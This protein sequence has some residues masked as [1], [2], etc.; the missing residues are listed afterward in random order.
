M[1]HNH[2]TKVLAPAEA[3]AAAPPAGAGS[4]RD[5][6]SS[7][8]DR[9]IT[10]AA[11]TT[12]PAQPKTPPAEPPPPAPPAEPPA[13]PP[14]AAP[15]TPPKP[16]TPPTPAARDFDKQPPRSAKEWAEA[17]AG[18]KAEYEPKLAEYDGRVKTLE[19][20]LAEARKAA[21]TAAEGTSKAE[22]AALEAANQEIEQLTETIRRLNVA[23]HP[24]FKAYFDNKVNAQVTLA[25]NIV[26]ADKAEQAAKVLAL[27]D[28]PY[29]SQQIEELIADLSPLQ[30]SR[31]GSVLNSLEAISQE[32]SETLEKEVAAAKERQAAET[33]TAEGKRE[34]ARQQAETAFADAIKARQAAEKGD[35]MFQLRPDTEEGAAEWNKAVPER[36]AL[37]KRYFTGEGM[38]PQDLM[39]ACFQAA[40]Y[41]VA[42]EQGLRLLK[43]NQTLKEQ[44]ARL[45]A[46]NPGLPAGGGRE[47]GGSGKP[48]PVK[49][50]TPP[51]QVRDG[52][53]HRL[54]S[55]AS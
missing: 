36:I 42:L 55:P 19:T 14:T 39:S 44:V 29:K 45:T 21:E 41:P 7:W 1:L 31:F 50:G 20:Q 30:S 23:E 13:T 35:P 2:L 22:K 38:K 52:F 27:P 3:P 37:A 24:R 6:I 51:S 54:T 18:I 11:P 25:K 12:P 43:E 10:P 32:R 26:G 47:G 49:P 16:A 46:A 48:P 5:I 8:M 4:T 34:Q 9:N 15:V 28:S 40:A 53:I 17:K 33:T